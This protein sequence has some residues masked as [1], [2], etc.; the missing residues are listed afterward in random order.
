MFT[1]YLPLLPHILTF[2]YMPQWRLLRAYPAHAHCVCNN[3]NFNICLLRTVAYLFTFT[4]PLLFFQMLTVA[5][6]IKCLE[7]NA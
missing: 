2:K 3:K 4:F 7:Q 6:Q 1:Q 5:N